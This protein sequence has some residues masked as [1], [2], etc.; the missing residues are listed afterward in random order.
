MQMLIEALADGSRDAQWYFHV[1]CGQK[2]LS[3]T[4]AV[5]VKDRKSNG[6]MHYREQRS[7]SRLARTDVKLGWSAAAARPR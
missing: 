5:Y 1:A 2:I 3:L 6:T 7:T 4:W